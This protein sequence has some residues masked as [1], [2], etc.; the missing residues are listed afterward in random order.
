LPDIPP[1]FGEAQPIVTL[2]SDR[3]VRYGKEKEAFSRYAY[4]VVSNSGVE[5]GSEIDLSLDP[6]YEHLVVHFVHIRRDGAVI[7]ALRT[8]DI[9]VVQRETDLDRRIYNGTLSALLFLHDVRVG[10]VID[11]AYTIAGANPILHGKLTGS[12][13]LG[14]DV[15]TAE[16]SLRLVVEGERSMSWK[17]HGID[18]APAVATNGPVTEY[19]WSRHLV[20]AIVE[21]DHLPFW[22]DAYPSVEVT[23]FASWSEVARWASD[24]FERKVD[25]SPDMRDAVAQFAQTPDPASRALSAIRFVQ[26]DVR[27]LGIE[28]GENGHQPFAPSQVLSRR[29]GDCKDKSLLLVTFLRALGFDASVALVD[30]DLGATVADRLPSPFAFDHAIAKFRLDGHDIFVDP[31]ESMSRGSIVDL[32]VPRFGRALV[33]SPESTG[34]AELPNPSIGAPL[35][36]ERQVYTVGEGDAPAR[37]EVE[38]VFRREEADEMRRHVADTPRSELARNYENYYAKVDAKIA[39]EHEPEIVDDVQT[40]VITVHEAYRIPGFWNGDHRDF[41]ASLVAARMTDPRITRRKM[42]L[43]IRHPEYVV[44]TI[45]VRLPDESEIEN[46]SKDVVSSAFRFSYR[47]EAHAKT[48]KLRYEYRTLRD[49]IDP[50]EMDAYRASLDEAKHLVD[51]TIT[52]PADRTNSLPA[53]V[54]PKTIAALVFG[55]VG[56]ILVAVVAVQAPALVRRHRF[57]RQQG[58]HLGEAHT[59]AIPARDEADRRRHLDRMRC[60]CGGRW[61]ATLEEV[62]V[63]YGGGLNTVLLTTCARCGKDGRLYFRNA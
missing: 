21:D 7:D 45:E 40:N 31:T 53:D 58:L 49:A 30:T 17:T 55:F 41:S 28:I 18:L 25:Q 54:K 39:S 29:F 3:Q 63:R 57:Q 32:T 27:Y 8:N 37:F 4:K 62:E 2:L 14:S 15:P 43:G 22:F 10:D 47:V 38:T 34:L 35:V 1:G 16:M 42:P 6:T 20:P 23:D 11:Y 52:R 59:T 60:G 46:E 13:H 26:D 50:S 5:N 36:E 48:F 19:V 44:E 33:V 9:K 56:I 12:Y 24:L 61:A 51:Y